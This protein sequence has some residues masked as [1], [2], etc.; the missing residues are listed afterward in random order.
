MCV[1]V[2]LWRNSSS[3]KG[4][5]SHSLH[6]PRVCDMHRR[7]PLERG[8]GD[9]NF[10]TALGIKSSIYNECREQHVYYHATVRVK[11]SHMTSHPRHVGTEK[12]WLG[13]RPVPMW[14]GN[15]ASSHVAWERG[16]FPCCLGIRLVPMWPGNEAS[17]HMAWE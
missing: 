16:Q 13:T 10:T 8:G 2:Y 5:Y 4:V 17:S 15:E 1:C 3:N 6:R 14:P 11:A 7:E 9:D 12:T